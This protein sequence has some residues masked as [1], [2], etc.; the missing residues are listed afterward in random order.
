MYFEANMFTNVAA[1]QL[2]QIYLLFQKP[3]INWDKEFGLI[4]KIVWFKRD[5]NFNMA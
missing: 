3:L 2:F 4:F 5:N 1:K